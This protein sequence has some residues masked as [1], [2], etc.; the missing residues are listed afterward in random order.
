MRFN[1][2]GVPRWEERFMR[3][4]LGAVAPVIK[5]RLAITPGIERFDERDIFRELDW[6]A[7]LL[8]DGRPYLSGE[9]FGAADLTF[10][11]LSAAVVS[12]RTTASAAR[13]GGAAAGDSRLRRARPRAPGGRVRAVAGRAPPA[14]A[15]G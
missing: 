14:R 10:G 1:N 3:H 8:S 6:V 5:R 12:P 11:A 9:R 7:E 15:R 2:A 13:A 4:G